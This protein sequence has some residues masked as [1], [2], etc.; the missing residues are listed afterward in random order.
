MFFLSF[1]FSAQAQYVIELNN[2]VANGEGSY[3]DVD[4]GDTVYIETGSRGALIIKNLHG[5]AEKPVIFV[6]SDEGIVRIS[7]SSSY[8][9]SIRNC[10]HVR[11]SGFQGQEDVYGI[12]ISDLDHPSSVGVS[13]KDLS[14][15]VEIDHIRISNTGFAGIVAKT[16]AVCGE[17]ETYRG[18][19]VQR[20]THIHHCHIYDTGGE[21]LYIGSTAFH[22][23]ES[24]DCGLI[25]PSVLEGVK[26]YNN[27]VER[28]K[29]DGIQVSSAVMDCQIY[30][31][32]LIDCSSDMTSSQMS[33]IIIGGGTRA[34]CFNNWIEDC[35]ATGI[36]VFGDGG[37]RVFNNVIVRPAKRYFP[38]DPTKREYGI[39]LN[40]K[41]QHN[42]TFYGVFSNTIIQPKSD[43]IRISE[44]VDFEVK[45]YNNLLVDP[46]AYEVYENDNTSRE[47]PDAFIFMPRD[48][49][50]I[51]MAANAVL[52]SLLLPHFVSHSTDDY[53]LMENSQYIDAGRDLNDQPGLDFDFDGNIRPIG[54]N[55]DIGAYGYDFSE[56]LPADTNN[57]PQ[58]DVK[59]QNPG[60]GYVRIIFANDT[61]M[62]LQINIL[63]SAGQ[64]VRNIS[65][66]NYSPG[67]HHLDFYK[68]P[69]GI[70]FCIISGSKW[71]Q[72]KKLVVH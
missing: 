19:F 44:T 37:T 17:P 57:S 35:Y 54:N 5:T 22:G 28:T 42:K 60:N 55:Y 33:G 11:L 66:Q 34:D 51:K 59:V 67:R 21:G 7:G 45:L 43:C 62:D 25:Y 29:W 13:V 50:L 61:K 4:P 10:T 8:G 32:S 38:D 48:N 20:N 12:Q 58:L 63:N 47:G 2:D 71:V 31:N 56:G 41:T 6:P 65:M 27:L 30:N 16:E 23:S 40:D 70:Y 53:H 18:A 24:G 26:I 49:P 36:L 9:V 69:D 52:R 64:M 39:Y 3:S 72:S 15:Y 1:T 68:L 14:S 46:G